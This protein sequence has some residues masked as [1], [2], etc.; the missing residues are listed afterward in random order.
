M[1]FITKRPPNYP[2]IDRADGRFEN[3]RQ[4]VAGYEAQIKRVDAKFGLPGIN[5]GQEKVPDKLSRIESR[6]LKPPAQTPG[7]TRIKLAFY[8]RDREEC[9][10]DGITPITESLV[11]DRR[12]SLKT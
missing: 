10:G 11:R 6:I 3:T 9:G 7:D 4:A 1:G 8:Q 12:R 2:A 5:R